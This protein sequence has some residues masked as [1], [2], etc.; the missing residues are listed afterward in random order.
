M[1]RRRRVL[2]RG[3]LEPRE[4]HDDAGDAIVLRCALSAASRAGYARIVT[5]QALG[6]VATRED[7]WHRAFEYLFERLVV[8]WTIAN[9][10]ELT[11]QRDLLARLRMASSDERRWLRERLREH[12]AEYFP[13]IEAP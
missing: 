12:C 3:G 5:G 10:P 9:A 8:S 13:E 4:Y 7:A 1:G 6:P 11:A 2:G